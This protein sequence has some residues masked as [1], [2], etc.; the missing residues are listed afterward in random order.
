M[1]LKTIAIANQKGGVGK[2]TTAVNLS[3]C[4]ARMGK[5]ILLV[6]LDPQANATD[7]LGQANPER[8]SES[9]YALIAEKS[10]DFSAIL[11]PVGPNLQL[12]P[13]HIALAEMDIKLFNTINRETR[14]QRSLQELEPSL[15]YV[16]I[17]C[18]PNLGITTVNAFCAATHVLIAIQ[19]NWFAYEALRRL[20]AIIQ[21]VI[22]ESNPELVVYALATIHRANVNVNR[23]VLDQIRRDFDNLTL[24]TAIPH[25]ATLVEASA[26]HKTILDYAHGSKGHRAYEEL[27][28]EIIRRVERPAEQQ[29]QAQV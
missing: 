3:A 12:A 2:T 23:D 4:L 16:I 22:D 1:A 19:T 15:D 24:E 26:D 25:T 8:E 6:D 17:D 13:G 11:R 28:Q 18:A 20:M 14:L 10:P 7:H 27:A 9:S 21:D 29:A 5:R